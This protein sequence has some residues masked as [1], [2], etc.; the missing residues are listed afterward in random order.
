MAETIY[1][2]S[3]TPTEERFYS[4]NSGYGVYRF[5]TSDDIPNCTEYNSPF[6]NGVVKVSILSGKVQP[7]ILGAEY[8][9]QA[10][11]SYNKKYKSWQ[12]NPLSVVSKAPKTLVQQQAFLKTIVTERQAKTLLD[13][14]PN[15]IDDVINDRDEVNV[16]RL[17]GI[18]KTTW[19]RIKDKIIS[20]YVISDIL[21]LLQPL[22]VTYNM[23]KKL[24]DNETNPVL[25]KQQLED[26]PY[27]LTRIHGLGFK[28]VDELALKI[29]SEL[30]VS[31]K[32]L[33]AYIVFY[34]REQG[35]QNGH[36]WVTEN[37]LTNAVNDNVPE[38]IDLFSLLIENERETPY[39]LYVSDDRIGLLSYRLKE[40]VIYEKLLDIAKQETIAITQ[41]EIEHGISEA[42]K[43]QGFTLT[44]EQ[45]ELVYQSTRVNLVVVSGKA[46]T[47]KTTVTRAILKVYEKYSKRCCALS[48]KAAQRITEATGFGATTIHRM[49]GATGLNTFTYN[50]DN[51][52]STK[53]LLIDECSMIS[54]EIFF[55]TLTAIN[56]STKVILC[57]DDKQL[58]PIGYG[59]IFSDILNHSETLGFEVFKLTKVLR[60]AEQSGI[61]SDANK[62]REGINPIAQP[63]FK[64]ITGELQDMVYMFRDDREVLQNL[65]IKTYMKSIES[66]GLDDVVIITPRKSNCTNSTFEINNKIQDL[67]ISDSVDKIQYGKRFY[68]VGAKI[69]QRVNNYD[70][71]VYN[72]EIGYITK[73]YTQII[74]GTNTTLFDVKFSDTKTVTYVRDEVDQIDLAY[75]LT[76]HLSQGSGY[77]TVIVVIDN[78][79]YSLLDTC[80]LYTGL[81]RAK[82]RCLLLAQPYAYDLCLQNNKGIN[83]QTWLS[84]KE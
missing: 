5:T 38:C 56:S 42:E 20:N 72:G 11:L 48:A 69:I 81:T 80:L 77:H 35:E 55:R 18:G 24:T 34:M 8:D 54:A 16:M 70:K 52:L 37:E 61:L 75:A 49:L 43:E 45:R 32:R 74:E 79:H 14:Y 40:K 71:G 31:D 53:V 17:N 60:Q 73:I 26:N 22:G 10:T 57:G 33:R 50:E 84:V 76:I 63:E 59:N 3:I 46:G 19:E 13:T 67:L 12:Y 1:T 58:P 41:E 68:K 82:Q 15:I 78:T 36:T 47:G 2:F 4:D 66:I 51:P 30:R 83:R 62:I 9:V 39:F 64:I 7:L 23:I 65:A 25:L 44:E 27:I 28:R 29:N 6:D 21:V